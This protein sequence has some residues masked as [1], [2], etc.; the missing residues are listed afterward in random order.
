MTSVP[1]E[2]WTATLETAGTFSLVSSS[3]SFSE[4]AGAPGSA[5]GRAEGLDAYSAQ[6]WRARVA[7]AR[8]TEEGRAEAAERMCPVG[9]RRRRVETGGVRE[10]ERRVVSGFVRSIV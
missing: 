6:I 7:R 1:A 4:F 3:S 9:V 10:E 2:R 8:R 5:S